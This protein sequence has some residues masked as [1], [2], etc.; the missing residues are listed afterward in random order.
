M[1]E[2]NKFLEFGIDLPMMQ[3]GIHV[4]DVIEKPE[5][6]CLITWFASMQFTRNCKVWIW[7]GEKYNIME[8]RD[9]K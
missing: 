2:L 3:E 7:H 5:I 9:T 8:L 1:N 4:L 6:L